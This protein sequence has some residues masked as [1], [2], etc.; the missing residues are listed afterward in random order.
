MTWPSKAGSLA[1]RCV[2]HEI[3]GRVIRRREHA[4]SEPR[5]QRARAELVR[6]QQRR[7]GVVERVGVR[8]DGLASPVTSSPNNSLSWPSS[9]NRTGVPAKRCQREH[10]SAQISR[11]GVGGRSRSSETPLAC[12]S[13]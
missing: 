5:E 11:G 8:S 2:R 10:S 3:V 1:S 6:R 7:D 13:G 12:S 4:D 9:Q